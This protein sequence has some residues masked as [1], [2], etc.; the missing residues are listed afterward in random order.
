MKDLII[1]SAL[2]I[3]VSLPLMYILLRM[4]FKQSLLV[5]FGMIWLMVQAI[6]LILTFGVGKLGSLTDFLWAFPIGISFMVV[7]Y[8]YLYRKIRVVLKTLNGKILELSAGNLDTIFD[9]ELLGRKDE[10]GEISNSIQ[11]LVK[12]LQEVIEGVKI[13][14]SIVSD[15]SNQLS[16]S[17]QQLAQGASEQAASVEEISSTMEQLASN[18]SQNTSNANQTR[19]IAGQAGS[20]MIEISGSVSK[21]VEAT[22]LISNKIKVITDIAFQTNILALNA[23]VEAAR[24]GEY[25]KGFAVVA[26][27]VRKLAEYSKDAA[28]EIILLTSNSLE[29]AE[30]S[31]IRM[32]DLLPEV[33]KTTGYVEEISASSH[34]QSS[35]VSQVNLAMQQ[36]NNITQQNAA[37]SEELATSAEELSV[38]ALRL[39]DVI[40]FFKLNNQLSHSLKNTPVSNL[41]KKELTKKPPVKPGTFSVPKSNREQ[42]SVKK[43]VKSKQESSSSGST[44]KAKT[45]TTRTQTPQKTSNSGNKLNIEPERFRINMDESDSGF[46]RF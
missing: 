46:E 11:L 16:S 34:E 6:L 2:I 9:K 3:G 18:I 37:A 27:E 41:Y 4:L 7:G 23:A 17:S 45:N 26:A 10:L 39:E 43:E 38:Q 12:K 28:G 30:K 31:A 35:N 29:L 25:G 24:A 22:R 19:K 42:T 32:K 36:L 14:L 40:S 8:L 21:S 20:E 33:E 5:T 44:I 13:N 15:A 1:F